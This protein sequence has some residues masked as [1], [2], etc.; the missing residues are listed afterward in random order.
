MAIVALFNFS[1]LA[2]CLIRAEGVD[3]EDTDNG[4]VPELVSMAL[5]CLTSRLGADRALALR[6]LPT[7]GTSSSVLFSPSVFTLLILLSVLELHFVPESDDDDLLFMDVRKS[8][9][10]LPK[11]PVLFRSRPYLLRVEVIEGPKSEFTL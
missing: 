9:A 7:L 6:N 1:P 10:I 3:R 4:L 2:S 8:N 11:I 5:F